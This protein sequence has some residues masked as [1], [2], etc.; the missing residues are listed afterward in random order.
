MTGAAAGASEGLRIL[1]VDDEDDVRASLRRLLGRL[2]GVRVTV[3]EAG[4]G[5][6]G[7]KA[8]RRNAYHLVLS[9]Y[10]MGKITGVDLLEIARIERPTT[11]RVLMTAF[12][13]MEIA[14]EAV[15]RARIEGLVHK[16]WDNETLLGMV[17]KLLAE[18]LPR[19]AAEP[20]G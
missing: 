5:E 2:P 14:R 3:D 13:E 6:D 10:R 18:H 17:G 1:V 7:I 12:A 19:P 11:V 20:R 4:S 9:D 16:P 15:N 8:L